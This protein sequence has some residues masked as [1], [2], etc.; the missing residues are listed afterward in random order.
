MWK[1]S[2]TRYCFVAMIAC[3]LFTAI[4]CDNM[5]D[6]NRYKP[7]ESSSFFE[8]GR[9]S[10]PLVNG[11]VARGFLRED[12]A[13]YTGKKQGTLI[14][15][16]PLD[17]T[18]ELILRGHNRYNIH[19]VVCH[20]PSGSGNG[21]AVERGFNQPPSFYDK[22]L[23]KAGAGHFY[24]VITNGRGV[25]ASYANQ[26]TPEDRWAVVAY[27]QHLQSLKP[28]P[29][30]RT[31]SKTEAKVDSK[32]VPQTKIKTELKT[33]TIAEDK[34]DTIT[35]IETETKTDTK[36]PVIDSKESNESTN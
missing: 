6:G 24:D 3:V 1:L 19:C 29:E 16:N 32:E 27:I 28:D 36:T 35:E 26:L 12:E 8:D 9:A 18:D 33:E 22:R 30:A 11:T 25:M 20:G 31:A 10:R 7:Y 23:R 34:A 14:S 15:K 17:I 4:G 5:R 21:L 2:K 13:M